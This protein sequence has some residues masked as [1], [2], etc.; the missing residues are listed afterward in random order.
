MEDMATAEAGAEPAMEVAHPVR[1]L[2]NHN[3]Y[4]C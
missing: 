2:K 3:M 4:R 1:G